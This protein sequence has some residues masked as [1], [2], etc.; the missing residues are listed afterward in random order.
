MPRFMTFGYPKLFSRGKKKQCSFQN[1][2]KFNTLRNIDSG[3]F[4]II[5]CSVRLRVS[6]IDASKI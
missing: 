5:E 1:I 2:Q 4:H 6:G 3:L